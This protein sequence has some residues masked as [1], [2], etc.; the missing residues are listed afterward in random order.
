MTTTLPTLRASTAG[1][2]ET[3]LDARAAII[4]LLNEAREMLATPEANDPAN[5]AQVATF[6]S[7]L[8][9]LDEVVATE[10]SADW[11]TL[12]ARGAIGTADNLLGALMGEEIDFR[13]IAGTFAPKCR[14]AAS[15]RAFTV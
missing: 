13:V 6:R 11:F 9:M 1:R 7:R 5:A 15:L 10:I 3:G 12:C 14:E 8:A 4:V 2:L